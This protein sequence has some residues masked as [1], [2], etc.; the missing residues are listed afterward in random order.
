MVLVCGLAAGYFAWFRDS[1][2]VA[3]EDV[4]VEGVT[5]P[6]GARIEAALTDAAKTMTTLHLNEEELA[7]AVEGF[8]TVVSVSAT[9]DFPHGVVVSVEERPPAVLLS[10]GK[11][12]VPVAGDG[13]LLRGLDVGDLPLPKVEVTELPASG[14][15]EGGPLMQATVVGAAPAPLRPLISAVSVEDETGVQVTLKGGIPVRFGTAERAEAK[16]AAASAVL[17]DPKLKTLTYVDVRVPERPAAGGAE[18]PTTESA[19]PDPA[20][21]VAVEPAPTDP[22]L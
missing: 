7:G 15:L 13:T 17:A 2:L 21:P 12:T 22:A 6:D 3:V 20:A 8:P 4:T 9:A 18:T 19:P 11:E 1:S 5:T 16:W 10:T 14:H